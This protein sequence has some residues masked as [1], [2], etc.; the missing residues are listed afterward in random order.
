MLEL[1]NDRLYL[2]A[3]A[4]IVDGPDELPREM[5]S[6]MKGEL[7]PSFVWIAGRYV[8]A[9][10]PN[11]NGQFWTYDDL[12]KGEKSIRYTPMNV[13]HQWDRPVGVFV[14]TK[15]VHRPDRDGASERLLPEVQALGA[16]WAAN[17]P[18]VAEKAKEYHAKKQLWYSMEC[19]AESKQCLACDEVYPWVTASADLC[20]HLAQ[21]QLAPRRFINPLFL[22][23]ALIFPPERPGWKDA[24]VTEVAHLVAQMHAEHAASP[25]GDGDISVSEWEHLMAHAVKG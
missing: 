23:G 5:A 1:I 12:Q 9:N 13:L 22:G 15:M 19:V 6:E 24:D 16:L 17:F 20:E 25:A 18:E 21:S 2:T 3:Q 4:R 14:E 11:Q 7:N 8:Q 10:E